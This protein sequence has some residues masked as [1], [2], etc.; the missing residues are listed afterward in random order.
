MRLLN[1]ESGDSGEFGRGPLTIGFTR[2]PPATASHEAE[3]EEKRSHQRPLEPLQTQGAGQDPRRQSRPRLP[4]PTPRRAGATGPSPQLAY[5][6]GKSSR[7]LWSRSRAAPERGLQA[8]GPG[9]RVACPCTPHRVTPMR[10]G[11]RVPRS[12]VCCHQA[13]VGGSAS[14]LLH[15]QMLCE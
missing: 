4:P 9:W 10:A 14:P 1:K 5:C 15:P 6:S 12:P 13:E 2:R 11:G 3:C 7:A 8:V